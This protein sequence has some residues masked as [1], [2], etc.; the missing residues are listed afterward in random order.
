VLGADAP[1]SNTVAWESALDDIEAMR[2]WDVAQYL[3]DDLLVKVDRGAMSASLE[4]RA[5]LLDHR[6]AELAFAL[7][8]NQLI[9]HGVGKWPLRELLK[10]FVPAAFYDRPKAGFSIPLA[11]WLRGPLRAW[12][13]DLLSEE[14]LKRE[15]Y[16]DGQKVRLAWLQH[17]RGTYDRSLHLWNILMFQSWLDKNSR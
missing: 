6:V 10:R 12:A 2:R 4:T 16:F 9:K 14:R 1:G 11:Q 15:G 7:S 3:P 8:S 13:E 17:Q 5:P